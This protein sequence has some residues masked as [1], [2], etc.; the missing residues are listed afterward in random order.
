[1]PTPNLV[2]EAIPGFDHVVRIPL[3]D[4]SDSQKVMAILQETFESCF[5]KGDTRM[6]VDLKNIHFPSSSL[7]ALLIEATS[8][9]RRLN[10]DLKIVNLSHSARNNLTTFSPLGYLSLEKDESFALKDFQISVPEDS[11]ATISTEEIAEDPILERLQ[12]SLEEQALDEEKN[13]HLRVKS[14]SNNLYTICDFV[15]NF[16]EKAG[17]NSKEI[18]KIKIAVYE[19]SLNVIEHAYRSNPD[20]W[21]DVWVECENQRFK[22]IIQDNGIGFEG[23]KTTDYNVVSAMDHRQT[24]GFGLYIIRRSMDEI[25]YESDRVN[26]NRLTLIK[27]LR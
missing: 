13:E 6:I 22:V 12:G 17:F 4:L 27:Y 21:I 1:M 25:D 14:S 11:A 26:G 10:G 5:S 2:V 8:R 23:L 19:A 18:G 16:A 9:A 24:G 7:I 15:T 20:N 3:G